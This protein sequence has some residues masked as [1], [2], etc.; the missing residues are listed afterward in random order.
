MNQ[1]GIPIQIMPNNRINQ[2]PG[3]ACKGNYNG[4]LN[5]WYYGLKPYYKNH[6][7]FQYNTMGMLAQTNPE[8]S[9]Y[10]IN[11]PDIDP[12][13]LKFLEDLEKCRTN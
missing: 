1:R 3:E 6:M 2:R 12:K 11:I 9:P 13:F 10:Y 4:N 7:Q 5:S 8:Y